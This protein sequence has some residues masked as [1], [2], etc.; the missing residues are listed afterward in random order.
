MIK[1]NPLQFSEIFGLRGQSGPHRDAHEPARSSE[2]SEM[3][4]STGFLL[5]PQPIL[6]QESLSLLRAIDLAG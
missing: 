2:G 6:D 4:S 1:L 3:S 5:P